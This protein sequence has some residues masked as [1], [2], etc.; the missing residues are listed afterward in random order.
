MDLVANH[1]GMINHVQPVNKFHQLNV[2]CK[3]WYQALPGWMGGGSFVNLVDPSKGPHGTLTLMDVTTVWRPGDGLGICGSVNFD[4]FDA[5]INTGS[6]TIL[7]G[8]DKTISLWLKTANSHSTD[9]HAAF[10]SQWSNTLGQAFMFWVNAGNVLWGDATSAELTWTGGEAAIEDDVWHNLVAVRKGADGFIY[11]DGILKASEAGTFTDTASTANV[12]IGAYY[13]GGAVGGVG[14]Y[15]GLMDGIKLLG[16]GWS[17]AQ[18]K[19][20]YELA[21][22]YNP[23]LINRI[24]AWYYG[25]VAAGGGTVLPFITNK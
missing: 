4:G 15:S 14:R 10:V 18:V 23:G 20:S 6:S 17:A 2:G 5:Y 25:P 19:A 21:L 12:L 1:L 7:G 22:E 24:P 8:G 13:N 11:M 9:S 16:E 3:V